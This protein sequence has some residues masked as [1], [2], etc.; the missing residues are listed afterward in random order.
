METPSFGHTHHCR[1]L[2]SLRTNIDGVIPKDS[3]YDVCI[4]VCV[5]NGCLENNAC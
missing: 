5:F 1:E 4:V 3:S 2:G